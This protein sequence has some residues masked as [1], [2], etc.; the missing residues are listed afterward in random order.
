MAEV[1]LRFIAGRHQGREF[2][3]KINGEIVIGRAEEVDLPLADETVSRKHAIIAIKNDEIVL[4]DC[5]KN[6]TYVNGRLMTSSMVLRPNDQIHIGRTIFK[7]I[8]LN[9]ASASSLHDTQR[10]SGGAA[11]VLPLGQHSQPVTVMSPRITAQPAILPARPIPAPVGTS[12]TEHFRGSIADI[13]LTDLLQLLITTRKTGILVLRSQDMIGRIYLDKG[14]ICHATFDDAES[15]NSLKVFYRLM[16]WSDGTFELE[17]CT[18]DMLT[19]TIVE[20]NDFLLLESMHQLDEI[21][22]LGPQLPPLHA[23]TVLANPLPAPLRD[24]APGDL[25]FIQLALRHKSV[26]S[27]LDHYAGSDFEGYTYL[28]SLIGRHYLTVA[29]S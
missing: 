10:Q 2:P 23:E 5:S 9:A 22:N 25:D 15:V 16:R 1:V 6:G 19:K 8:V 24:L 18:S 14:Q 17:P 4:L 28:K 26:R 12:T 3:L 13:A 7:L 27:I 29:E 20:T 11:S 21:N